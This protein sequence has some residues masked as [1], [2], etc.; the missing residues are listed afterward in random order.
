MIWI[1]VLPV[2]GLC[3]EHQ[4]GEGQRVEPLRL[5]SGPVMPRAC[6]RVVPFTQMGVQGIHNAILSSHSV[7]LSATLIPITF[8]AGKRLK[9]A[10]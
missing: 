9:V 7:R 5:G 4:I 6:R 1:E 8:F 2:D 3:P 10:R